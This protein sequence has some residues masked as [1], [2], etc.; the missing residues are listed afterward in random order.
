MGLVQATRAGWR[1]LIL[2][3]AAGAVMASAAHAESSA[4]FGFTGADKIQMFA[5]PEGVYWITIQAEG[6]HG[7]SENDIA[8]AGAGGVAVGT[9][10]VTPGEV[11]SIYV[12]EYGYGSHGGWGWAHGGAHGN[13]IGDGHDGGGGGGAT[14]VL[15]LTDPIVIAGGG[16]GGGGD[17]D[18]MSVSHGWGGAGGNGNGSPGK[19]A[20][21]GNASDGGGGCGGCRSVPEGEHGGSA[22]GYRGGGGG[23]G[24]GYR[25]GQGGFAGSNAGGGGGGGGSS[26]VKPGALDADVHGV[27]SRSRDG[28]VTIS[29]GEPAAHVSIAGGD[30]QSA[31]VGTSFRPLRV[32]VTTADGVPASGAKVRFTAPD[33]E[34]AGRFAGGATSATATVDP[35]GFATAPTLWAGTIAGEWGLDVSVPGVARHE[36]FTLTN[37]AAT[38]T[39]AITSSSPTTTVGEAV[40]FTAVVAGSSSSPNI[41]PNG[42]VQFSDGIVPLGPPV[43]LDADGRATTPPLTGLEVGTHTVRAEY[44]GDHAHDPSTGSMTQTVDRLPVTVTMS[45]S[46]NPSAAGESILLQADVSGDAPEGSVQFV[47]DGFPYEGPQPLVAGSAIAPPI[48]TLSEGTHEISGFYGGDATHAPANGLLTQVVGDDALSVTVSAGTNP[49]GSG[50]PVDLQAVV[51]RRGPGAPPTGQATFRAGSTELCA[52]V[53]VTAGI[54]RCRLSDA[55]PVGDNTID[56]QVTGDDGDGSGVAVLHVL[57]IRTTVAVSVSP[58]PAPFAQEGTIEAT[59][60]PIEAGA[61]TPT[62]TVQLLVDGDPVGTPVTL[63]DGHVSGVPL[64][65]PAQPTCVLTPGGHVVEAEYLGDGVAGRFATSHAATTH[66]VVDAATTTTVTSDGG[67]VAPF[68]RAVTVTARVAAPPEAGTAHGTVQFVVDGA[69]WGDP[70]ALAGGRAEALPL[71]SLAPGA[72]VVVARY[73]GA[74][75]LAPSQAQLTQHVGAAPHGGGGGG[76]S[77]ASEGSGA[78]GGGTDTDTDAISDDAVDDRPRATS[79][80]RTARVDGAGSARIGVRCTGPAGQRCRG[81]LELRQE[82]S[83]ARLA[84][85]R[86]AIRTGETARLVVDLGPTGQRVLSRHARVSAQVRLIAEADSSA[87]DGSLTLRSSAAPAATLTSKRARAASDGDVRVPV[88]CHAASGRRCHATLTLLRGG[89]HVAQTTASL[90]GGRTSTVH[91]RLA[92]ATRADLTRTGRLVARARVRSSLAVGRARQ[93]DRRLVVIAR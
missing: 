56:V 3:L 66:H 14:A 10:P 92:A 82:G 77:S 79:V 78:P 65:D 6:G 34:P 73:D 18:D 74:P 47:L 16:G 53:P 12:G 57:P 86:Y 21:G 58:T 9:V 44:L 69:A 25:G 81:R 38:T 42:R 64:C 36:R 20:R 29:W 4:E 72:H 59:V 17:A 45:S 52:D 68:G 26:W 40:R 87:E 13:V 50:A 27:S 54:A 76:G 93:E 7:G 24:G 71:G 37:A 85:R 88:R 67:D 33:D 19:T 2:A 70:V 91:L 46:A 60:A 90:K 8:P 51:A 11:L 5:V 62:G 63:V 89:R 75:G 83:G 49:V 55:L 48:D 39:T 80:A 1:A 61:P 35:D 15:R 31:T 41:T 84:Q 43:A 23:S 22:D 32:K 28:H 30:H